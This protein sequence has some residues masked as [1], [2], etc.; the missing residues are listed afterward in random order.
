MEY[1]KRYFITIKDI[2]IKRLVK[3][4]GY[5]L[6][7][8]ID[9]II[10]LKLS[11]YL[12]RFDEKEYL[13]WKKFTK[14]S[15]NN[16]QL[17]FQNNFKLDENYEFIFCNKLIK[18]KPN[19]NWNNSSWERLWQFNLHY[20][21]WA[22]N[23]IEIYLDHK[24]IDDKLLRIK[25]LI[26]HWIDKNDLGI[27]DGWHSYTISLRIRNWIWAMRIFPII[28][29]KKILSST[30]EQ[31]CWL[32]HHL[33]D[34]NGGNHYLE[35]LCALLIGSLQFKSQYSCDIFNFC[36]KELN[37]EL[38]KQILE[39]GGHEE[40]SASYHILL[41]DRLV[42]VCAFLK[43]MD[44]DIPKYLLE[45]IEQ[46][47]KWTVLIRLNNG[48]FPRFNDS[49][50]NG[51]PN[52][53]ETISFAQ[54]FLKKKFFESINLKGIRKKLIEEIGY[55]TNMIQTQKLYKIKDLKH[56]GWTFIKPG[57]GWEIIFK[58]GK[59]CPKHLPGHAHSDLLTFD[60]YKNGIPIIAECG[61]STYENNKIRKYER[62]GRAHNTFE[63][64]NASK[65]SKFVKQKIIEPIDVW[66]SFRAGRKAKTYKRNYGF[67]KNNT[68][69]V[70]ASHDGYSSL[71]IDYSRKIT[72]RLDNDGNLI[73]KIKNII[74]SGKEF[75]W[76]QWIHFSPEI[77]KKTFK[78]IIKEI[79]ENNDDDFLIKR[80]HYSYDFG[81]RKNRNSICFF[82]LK[83][84]G[85]NFV[86][87]F[88]ILRDF[89]K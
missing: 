5:D 78:K 59:S 62:S 25:L 23:S 38:K 32:F 22:R 47:L 72:F 15:L 1:F 70:S 65:E 52:I 9:K 64:L 11:H 68:F 37:I 30:W 3:R 16:N 75:S 80:T 76:R 88:I 34:A 69:W 39:D 85:T 43:L 73:I 20:F 57:K 40:R 45:T 89:H 44:K 6:R 51:C 24:I 84:K 60:I 14:L 71:N 8:Q 86:N 50:I 46:M 63:I 2:G 10:P 79:K 19:F 56:T 55:K 35:N 54:A 26:N 87:T 41:L 42:E 49:S 77:D 21:D 66:S 17:F 33:E 53:D 28:K 82:G 29:N 67:T 36:I 7:K 18:L 48:N 81:D 83:D 74:S 13:N 27:G 58:S 61:T 31:I 12:I 4:L